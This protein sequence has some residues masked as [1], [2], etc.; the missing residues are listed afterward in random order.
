[1]NKLTNILI[2]SPSIDTNNNISGI[3]NLTKLLVEN[4]REIRY[5]LFT[6]GK[7]DDERRDLK[8][9]IKQLLLPISFVNF[10]LKYNISIVHIN[11]PLEKL[12]SIVNTILAII[13][14]LSCK[15][16]IIHVHG[17]LY[18]KNYNT[19]PFQKFLIKQS[20]R[21]SARILT[22]GEEE[23]FFINTY[24]N[25]SQEKIVVLPNSVKVSTNDFIIKPN[26]KL[27]LL[28][29]GRIDKNKGLFEIIES[30]KLIPKVMDF[31]LNV[32]GDGPDREWFIH[33]LSKILGNKFTYHSIVHGL[34]KEKLLSLANIFLLPSYYEGLPYALLEAMSFGVVPIVTPVGSI[35]EV[36]KHNENGLLVAVHNHI[37]IKNAITL[38]YS[39]RILLNELSLNAYK[40]IKDNY[41]IENYINILNSTYHEI[42]L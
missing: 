30:L 33:E 40:T 4:N 35:P 11:M 15:K 25:I 38:L 5:I 6:V 27:E 3:S 31:N 2:T 14:H 13:C 26:S 9:F 39:N 36:V 28:Y 23:S 10:L 19:P 20:L 16:Y 42:S 18:N 29:L 12:A 1:M 7:K 24:Y 8:W 21:F 32:A 34:T 41:S 17:G 37:D 22:L